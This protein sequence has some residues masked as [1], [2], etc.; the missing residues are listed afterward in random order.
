MVNRDNEKENL[1][2]PEIELDEYFKRGNSDNLSENFINK[3][4]QF[5][6]VNQKDMEEWQNYFLIETA[7]Y[8]NNAS[9][10]GIYLG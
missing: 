7:D 8:F 3:I 1:T 4:N 10:T 2:F 9:D 5:R 6:D